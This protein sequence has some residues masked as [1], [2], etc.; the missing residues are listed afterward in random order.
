M[1]KKLQSKTITETTPEVVI[2]AG[3]ADGQKSRW[4][5]TLP[6]TSRE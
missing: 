2:I 1:F 3:M 6:E 4:W 5:S